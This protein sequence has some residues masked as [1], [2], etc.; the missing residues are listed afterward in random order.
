MHAV[1]GLG[2][3]GM[4]VTL[5]LA[6][7]S[8]VLRYRRSDAVVRR[9]LKWIALAGCLLP[10]AILSSTFLDNTTDSSG[11]ATSLPFLLL[12]IA[13]PASIGVA[14]LRYRLWDVDRVVATTAVYAAV[15]A[16]LA[17]AFVAVILVG[18]VLIGGGSPVTTA[19][20]TL[21]VALAFRPRAS[22]RPGPRRPRTQPAALVR[23]AAGRRLPGRPARGTA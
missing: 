9:Q 23:R 21:A 11:V 16:L 7:T 19:A 13:L 17:A 12:F 15:T 1:F 2:L 8:L 4:T 3:L 20:A 6:A 5:V 10:V 18:G 22:G 14:V